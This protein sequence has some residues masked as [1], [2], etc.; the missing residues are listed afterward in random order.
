MASDWNSLLAILDRSHSLRSSPTCPTII[1]A[2]SSFTSVQCRLS[3]FPLTSN[4]EHVTVTPEPKNESSLVAFKAAVRKAAVAAEIMI[5]DPNLHKQRKK[6][7]F[8]IA[9]EIKF[10][11]H[12]VEHL[13][14][15]L[16]ARPPYNFSEREYI[17]EYGF[18]PD[19]Y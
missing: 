2:K 8:R 9:A 4:P 1:L 10:L 15:P 13:D 11:A 3:N 14:M 19:M 5:R 7:Y 16:H 17:R 18:P 12:H 6:L